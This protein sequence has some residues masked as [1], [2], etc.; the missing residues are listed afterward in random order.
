MVEPLEPS[1]TYLHKDECGGGMEAFLDIFV[2]VKAVTITYFSA[3]G[4]KTF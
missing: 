3:Q 2:I 4:I 1:Q